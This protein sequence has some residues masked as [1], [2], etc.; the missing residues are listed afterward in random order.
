M[1]VRVLATCRS[2]RPMHLV[3]GAE[4][5][6][7]PYR[8]DAPVTD[9]PTILVTAP[10]RGEGLELLRTRRDVVDDPWIDDAAAARSGTTTELAARIEEEGADGRHLR[11]RLRASG[12]VLD[13]PLRRHRLD[14]RRP[15]NV[16]VAGATA[17][18]HPGAAR[19]G[20]QRRRRGRDDRR[21]ALRRHPPRR[22]P[23][24]AD[25]RAGEVFRDG[26]DPLPALPGV[27]GRRAAP[28]ASSASAPSAGPLKWRL[29]GLGH[30]GASP[31]TRTA[32]DATHVARRRC[33]A[34]ADVVSMHA[35]VTPET[36][37]MIGRR[38]SSRAMQDGRVYLNSARAGA[39]RPRRA[40][41]GARS[42][43]SSAAPAS[44]TSRASS[45]PTGHPLLRDGQRRAHAPHRRRHLRHRGEPH[46]DDRRRHRPRSSPASGPSHCANPEVLRPMSRA[47]R[48]DR[49]TRSATRC[50]PR[51]RRCTRKGLV[52]GTAGNVSGRRRRRHRGASR[53]RRS[54]TTT[55]T[56]DDLVVVDLDG[57]VVEGDARPDVARRR[58][59]SRAT[60]AYPEV[61]GGGPLPRHV[62]LDV[63]RA[64]ASPSRP[65]S[66]SSSSTS[67]ATCPCA[68]TA[69]P[70]PTSW[71]T[72]WP[73]S[74]ATAARA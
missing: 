51:P 27:A 6:N 33:S 23:A 61:G 73:R 65:P 36:L 55:M 31:S 14:P 47:A 32:D 45:C 1:G 40:H 5:T 18:G 54:P 71:A 42:R 58:C 8:G 39:A 19:A 57:N 34:E 72:R 38:R 3:R 4:P 52:E 24:D 44:T 48:R 12:A 74:S 69:R 30:A 46:A 68:S 2:R 17:Q 64:P 62:R 37:G 20:P 41:R 9:G 10:F 43:A 70:A 16:D 60:R 11:G 67:A 35:A 49:S 21:P 66:T 28:P 56:L 25:V 63:R 26:T 13:R 50:S 29:E 7:R 59:T 53:R 22:S 15:T